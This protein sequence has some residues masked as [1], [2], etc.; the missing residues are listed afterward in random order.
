VLFSFTAFY[1]NPS[2]F[3]LV[4][5]PLQCS[6]FFYGIRGHFWDLVDRLL[7]PFFCGVLDGTSIRSALNC[8]A[9]IEPAYHAAGVDLMIRRTE[10]VE[11]S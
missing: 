7:P 3:T 1:S 2:L 10:L 9:P 11:F 5:D 8:T 6:Y 4:H